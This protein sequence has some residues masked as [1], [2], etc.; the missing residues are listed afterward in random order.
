MNKCLFDLDRESMT[1]QNM[2]TTKDQLGEPMNVIGVT[3]GVWVRGYLK[4]QKLPKPNPAQV[5]AH[6]SWNLELTAQPAGSPKEWGMFSP[7]NSV[8][9][10]L[11]GR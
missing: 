10:S 4:E 7:A 6:K 1:V 2:D 3:S 11:L 8:G 9:L 5:T